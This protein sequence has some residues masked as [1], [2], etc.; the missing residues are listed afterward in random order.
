MSNFDEMN[1]EQFGTYD[2]DDRSGD[3]LPRIQWRQGDARTGT[4]GYFFLS[5]KNA[6]DGFAPIGE[7]WKPHQE[8][9]KEA[10]TRDD[11]WKAEQLPIMV[12]C[13]RG[14]PFRKGPDGK[15]SQ[16]LE[17][18]PKNAEPNTI[19]QH[20]DVL[21]VADGLQDL[22]PVCWSTN[23]STTAF[24]I[25]GGVDPKRAP[26]GGILHRLREEVLAVADKV[27]KGMKDRK[28]KR[29]YWL[30]WITISTARDAKGQIVY[31]PTKSGTDVTLPVPLLPDAV[32]TAWLS[33][34]FVGKDSA[35]YGKEMRELYDT[36]RAT[37]FTNDAPAAQPAGKNVPQEMSAED[38]F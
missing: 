1:S 26:K 24:A 22:G 35:I 9:F 11:G 37:R 30:F 34:N 3:G 16:W 21:L 2:D 25:I 32:D 36:W 38:P 28:V 18:W 4:P 8:Y 20:V 31:T 15:R 6:P 10:R 29:L 27:S 14:Q 23:S 5:K 7:A 12:I 13:A 33:E 17:S 19:A